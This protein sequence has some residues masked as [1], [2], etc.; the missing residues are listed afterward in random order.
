MIKDQ[1]VNDLCNRI[2]QIGIN[3][4]WDNHLT[5]PLQKN[6]ASFA[7]LTDQGADS[8]AVAL[9]ASELEGSLMVCGSVQ[10]A[11]MPDVTRLIDELYAIVEAYEQPSQA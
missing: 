10:L 4:K 3:N 2:L 7:R 11:A 8:E 5:E 6:A 9:A 1:R